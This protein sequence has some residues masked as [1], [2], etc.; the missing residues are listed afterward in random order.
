MKSWMII[1]IMLPSM[2]AAQTAGKR[3][4]ISVKKV[5]IEENDIENVP[6]YIKNVPITSGYKVNN[7]LKDEWTIK[8]EPFKVRKQ[9][10]FDRMVCD[11]I[12]NAEFFFIKKKKRCKGSILFNSKR[13]IAKY[14]LKE[15]G[16]EGYRFEGSVKISS[17]YFSADNVKYK[18]IIKTYANGGFKKI[19]KLYLKDE[20]GADPIIYYTRI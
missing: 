17:E 18:L 4:S 9:F 5:K 1:L 19:L 16:Y 11:S 2:L 20:K 13:T 8:G 10:L 15:H 7:D 3:G 14:S 12:G 6:A